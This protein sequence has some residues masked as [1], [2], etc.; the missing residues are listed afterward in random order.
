MPSKER[1]VY[2]NVPEM[3]KRLRKTKDSRSVAVAMAMLADYT[4]S[5]TLAF[6]FD[7]GAI[8]RRV[9]SKREAVTADEVIGMKDDL[10]LFFTVL[11]DGR[12]AANPEMFSAIDGNPGAES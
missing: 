10:L 9:S 4:A 6:I 5:A 11:P 2:I 7:P 12:W 1:P 3:M 8:A